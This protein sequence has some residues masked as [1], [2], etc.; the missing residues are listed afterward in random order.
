MISNIVAAIIPLPFLRIALSTLSFLTFSLTGIGLI[1]AAALK[2]NNLATYLLAFNPRYTLAMNGLKA[3]QDMRYSVPAGE[4]DKHEKV[5]ANVG[6]VSID[7]PEW[8]VMLEFVRSETAIR[9]SERN[10]PATLQ[11]PPS[12]PTQPSSPPLPPASSNQPQ[13]PSPLQSPSPIDFER[14]KTIIAFPMTPVLS[15]GTKPLSPPYS[16][17]V[18]WPGLTAHR[19]YEFLSF[20]EFRLDLRHMILDEMEEWSLW[21]SAIA[22]GCGLPINVLR[23]LLAA[24]THQR[25]FTAAHASP[26]SLQTTPSPSPATP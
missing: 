26:S 6:V 24:A 10:E 19:V 13:P 8:S 7:D 9:K 11:A 5:F 17:I 16:L 1:T 2:T 25:M 4:N 3:L 22:F 12:P 20:E 15:A 14:V 23:S 18:L 21:I